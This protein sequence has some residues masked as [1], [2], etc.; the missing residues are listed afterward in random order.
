V[1]LRAGKPARYRRFEWD[2]AERRG[3]TTDAVEVKPHGIVI[4]DG[5]YCNRPELAE[6]YDVSVFVDT[7]EPTRYRRLLAR[8][9]NDVEWIDRWMAADRIYDEHDPAGRADLVVSG[10]SNLTED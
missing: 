4:V 3:L 7:P 5:V 10:G 8:G 2:A 6:L 1:P 9:Q